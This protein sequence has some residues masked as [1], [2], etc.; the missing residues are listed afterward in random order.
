MP[1]FFYPIVIGILS[2]AVIILTATAISGPLPNGWEHAHQPLVLVAFREYYLIPAAI[3]VFFT[4]LTT[5][6]A[7][8]AHRR[9]GLYVM[10]MVLGIIFLIILSASAWRAWTMLKA[11]QVIIRVKAP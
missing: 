10:Q 6:H 1:R 11:P 2:L 5:F 8:S 3:V 7:H 9:K 4:V